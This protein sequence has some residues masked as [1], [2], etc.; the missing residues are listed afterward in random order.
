MSDLDIEIEEHRKKG[1]LSFLKPKEIKVIAKYKKEYL[2]T[3]KALKILHQNLIK[4]QNVDKTQ[5]IGEGSKVRKCEETSES[6]EI[7]GFKESKSKDSN[8][9][10]FHK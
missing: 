1:F 6:C 5:K 4:F 9:E 8:S 7:R 3:H 10:K 2:D